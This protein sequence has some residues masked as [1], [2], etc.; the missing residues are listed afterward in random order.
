VVGTTLGDNGAHD[1]AGHVGGLVPPTV[2]RGADLLLVG[3]FLCALAASGSALRL[4]WR[5]VGVLA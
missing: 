3:L 5:L 1:E 4:C 2:R